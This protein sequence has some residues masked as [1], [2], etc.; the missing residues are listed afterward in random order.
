M[1]FIIKRLREQKGWSQQKLAELSGVPRS[2]LGE[3]ETHKRLPKPEY[4][5]G[6]ARALGVTV[7]DLYKGG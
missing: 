1:T 2:T 4:L 6:I 5:A 3:I 7:E